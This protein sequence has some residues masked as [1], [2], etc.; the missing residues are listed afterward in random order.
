VSSLALSTSRLV[1]VV[2]LANRLSVVLPYLLCYHTLLSSAGISKILQQL[3]FLGL[4]RLAPARVRVFVKFSEAIFFHPL[5]E[6]KGTA[7]PFFITSPLSR[8]LSQSLLPPPFALRPTTMIEKFLQTS[9]SYKGLNLL[10][11]SFMDEI[12]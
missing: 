6:T 7:M 5:A 12:D 3:S 11:N 1:C 4:V 2:L 9:A 10:K 8:L